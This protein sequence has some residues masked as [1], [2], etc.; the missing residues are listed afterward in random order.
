MDWMMMNWTIIW[1]LIILRMLIGMAGLMNRILTV[2]LMWIGLIRSMNRT[3]PSN[4]CDAGGVE[5]EN[6]DVMVSNEMNISKSTDST[7]NDSFMLS[8]RL[9]TTARIDISSI[10]R[11]LKWRHNGCE[12]VSNHQ[13]CDS[14]LNRLFK[15]RL[16]KTS[17]LRVTG[18]CAENSPG[19]GEFPAQMASNAENVSIWWRHHVLQE[20]MF[21]ASVH[22]EPAKAL[23]GKMMFIAM[24]DMITVVIRIVV[25]IAITVTS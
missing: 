16:K 11:P 23:Q 15:H 17:K 20:M 24:I 19:T 13:P 2:P 9:D 5:N 25:K 22:M 21:Q 3:L 4:T 12:S 7:D 1:T 8:D 14:L 18:L 6:I 10:S